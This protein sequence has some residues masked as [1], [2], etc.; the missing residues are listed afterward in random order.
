MPAAHTMTDSAFF[1]D[2]FARYRRA[3]LETD[4]RPELLAFRDLCLEVKQRDGKL[5]FAGNGASASIASHAAVDFTKQAKVRAMAFNDHNL[6][7]AF[8]NDY[9]YENW[10]SAALKA[11]GKPGDAV[12]LISSSGKSPNIVNAALA[13][14]ELGLKVVTFSGFEKNSQL[15]NVGDINLWTDSRAY[16]IIEAVHGIWIFAVVDLIV[17]S[18]EYGVD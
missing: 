17:G 9:G 13:A 7:T 5:I 1:D 11:Y 3:L 14:R 18:A 10:V 8:S 6:I 4:V 2:Y 16:N 15:R 12:V